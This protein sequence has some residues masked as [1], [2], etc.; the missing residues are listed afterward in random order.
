MLW[1][2]VICFWLLDAGNNTS[3]EPYRAFIS[4]RL[5]KSQLARGFLT[6]SMFTGAGAVLANLSLF[7][8]QKVP[9][10][11]KTAGNGVPYWMYVCF[12]IGT[13]CILVTVLTAM[14]RTKELTPSD[15]E[16]A[17]IRSAPEGPRA[18]RSSTSRTPSG[19]CR[20]RCTRSAWCSCSSGTRCSSTG[21]SWRSASARRSSTPRPSRAARPGTRRSPGAV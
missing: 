16:L 9:A 18:T 4:D 3:M 12:M 8:L 2:A 5:P 13:V 1:L 19:R 15:E 14:A 17:E 21:S 7:V 11:D 6:Q 10:L 20:S